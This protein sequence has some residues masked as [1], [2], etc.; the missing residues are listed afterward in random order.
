MQ[1]DEFLEQSQSAGA[2][3][4]IFDERRDQVVQFVVSVEEVVS[5]AQIQC[6]STSYFPVVLEVGPHRKIA[7]VSASGSRS[8]DTTAAVRVSVFPLQQWWETE[9]TPCGVTKASIRTHRVALLAQNSSHTRI[10]LDLAAKF[11]ENLQLHHALSEPTI[12]ISSR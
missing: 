9:A 10:E 3:S 6:Q 8:T 5:E 2:E 11:N 12:P 4:A 1:S 7:P